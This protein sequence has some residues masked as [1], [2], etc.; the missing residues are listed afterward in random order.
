[1]TRFSV[2]RHDLPLSAPFTIAYDTITHARNL[3]VTATRDGLTG[4]GEAAPVP[5][6]TGEG[7]DGTVAALAS[8]MDSDAPVDGVVPRHLL[9]IAGA[10]A[11]RTALLD[12]AAKEDGDPLCTFLTGRPPRSL[13]TSI[14]IP[15]LPPEEA[16]ALAA[17]HRDAGFHIFKVKAGAGLEEDLERIRCVRDAV[18]GDEIRVD[19]NQGW[20]REDAARAIG[21]LADLGVEVLEQP[22]RKDDLEG[23]V[24]LRGQ[25]IP[26]MLDESVFSPD[27]ARQAIKAGACDRINIKLQKTGGIQEA[28]DIATIAADAGIPCMLGCMIESRVGILAAAHTVAAH[29]NIHWADLDGH[30]FLRD[31][32]VRG[33]VRIEEGVIHLGTEAGIGIESV[34]AQGMLCSNGD[35]ERPSKR[36]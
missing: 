31:D 36:L 20:S 28:L 25:G 12:L 18:H 35:V 27:H 1:M 22:L 5:T 26:V 2:H 13:P 3:L 9:G 23:N 15:I 4:Y 32:P 33:G 19:A 10:L 11:C 29:D 6:I 21:P 34:D 17:R 24:A 16:G 8:W 7:Q 30:T 14:T